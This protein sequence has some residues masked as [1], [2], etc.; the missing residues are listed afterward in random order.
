MAFEAGVDEAGRGVDDDG[1]PA[2]RGSAF[3][4]RDK[5]AGIVTRS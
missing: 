4:L 2:Q 1:E 5:V 3:H